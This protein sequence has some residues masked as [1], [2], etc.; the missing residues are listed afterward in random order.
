MATKKK[1]LMRLFDIAA[2]T[3][4][5]SKLSG[6]YLNAEPRIK[7]KLRPG[8]PRTGRWLCRE[9][10]HLVCLFGCEGDKDA[11]I[12]YI[13]GCY[14]LRDGINSMIHFGQSDIVGKVSWYNAEGWLPCLVSEFKT[15]KLSFRIENF[16]DVCTF[17][18]KPLSVA[19]S[20]VIIENL[21]S[22]AVR[23]PAPSKRLTPLNSATGNPG[24]LEPGEKKCFDYC[25]AADRFGKNFERPSE[26][27]L[28]SF[29]S[30]DSRY[31]SMKGRW[32]KRLEPLVT[33]DLP[34][35][36]LVNA[37][38]AG[39][40][41]TMIV[42]DGYELHVGEN[43][44][45]RVFDHDVIG[46]IAALLAM[47]DT[48]YFDE[49]TKYILLN[50]Q[51][52]DA[53]WKYSF[54]FAK[55]LQMTGD[56]ALIES[57]FDEISRNTHSIES[58]RLSPDG[59]MKKS[60]S[61]DSDGFWT[62]DN[63]SALTGLAA[64]RY[65]CLRL[66]KTDEA[67]WALGQYGSLLAATNKKLSETAKKYSL[68]YIP[69]SLEVPNEL[70]ARSDKRD[71]NRLSMFLFGRWS[72]EAHLFCEKQEGYMLDMIDKT[73]E[74]SF[75]VT[76]KELGS[77]YNFGGY[78]H[79]F[80]CSAYN[81]GYGSAA[82]AGKKHRD[83]AIKAYQFML[84]NAQS[85]PFGWWE[86]VDYPSDSSPWDISHAAAGGGSCPH[87]WGQ[88]TA[89]KALLDSLA[90][91]RTDGTAIILRG[92][93]DEWLIEGKHVAVSNIPAGTGKFGFIAHGT[94]HGLHLELEG[95]DDFPVSVEAMLLEGKN[96]IAP[97]CGITEQGCAVIPSGTKTVD[98]YFNR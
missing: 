15:E 53:R 14:Y 58:D 36:N 65:I 13:D 86:G 91:R 80:Y 94:E 84:E 47:G 87:I 35:E 89:T 96:I 69:I 27:I 49:Y 41:Y 54:V 61:I 51:Y 32:T 17:E 29:G 93:P 55:Y 40:V 98:I 46:I 95:N 71:A 83:T 18:N 16:A 34:D 44:Y 2:S 78:P 67:E 76:E 38:K 56:T 60:N 64:Y 70:S 12:A 48:E 63:Q 6:F 42:K 97:G 30:F 62:I 26:D 23:V 59:V 9:N 66:G 25:V 21:S 19:Y 79:G 31:E 68:D 82:L 10:P 85:G 74:M 28:R 8:L 3:N 22:T 57:R 88:A 77:K 20:R 7:A 73:Y 37:Y 33:L 72:W 92:V 52:S 5:F 45:D 39:Y 50:V 4:L 43:G 90:C 24:T 75:D 1:N 81:A 11:P